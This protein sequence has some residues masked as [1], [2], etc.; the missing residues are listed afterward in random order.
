[1]SN[2]YGREFTVK[3]I[4]KSDLK[5]GYRVKLRNNNICIIIKDCD[6]DALGE[7][8]FIL[9]DCVSMTPVLNNEFYMEEFNY[10]DDLTAKGRNN[11]SYDI[12]EVRANY[13]ERIL[14]GDDYYDLP[15]I[16]QRENNNYTMYRAD[17]EIDNGAR[18]DKHTALLL[19]KNKEDAWDKF[20]EL[21]N[22]LLQ[23]DE[24]VYDPKIEEVKVST[25]SFVYVDLIKKDNETK[26]FIIKKMKDNNYSF[27]T[28]V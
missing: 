27:E 20:N 9:L 24:S 25:D 23:Y 13:G 3:T 28:G 4:T 15:I 7:L 14:F 17:F 16:W 19:A 26:D 11:S 10:N 22:P 8:D 1:M 18:Y 2:E 21:I 12:I 5:T 6:T